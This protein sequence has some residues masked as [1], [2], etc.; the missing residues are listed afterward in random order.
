M[1]INLIFWGKREVM[2]TYYFN[3]F[4]LKSTMNVEYFNIFWGNVHPKTYL[5]LIFFLDGNSLE[6]VHNIFIMFG[7]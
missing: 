1:R 4:F 5:I 6:C 7:V 2:D 3:N